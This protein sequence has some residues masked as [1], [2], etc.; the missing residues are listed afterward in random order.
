MEASVTS[1]PCGRTSTWRCWTDAAMPALGPDDL[2]ASYWTLA[3]GGYDGVPSPR[4]I[5]SRADAA[6]RAGF[7]GIGLRH[8]DFVAARDA[9][10][11][12]AE[13]R[14]AIEA[15]GVALVELE[16]VS[17]WSS[18]DPAVRERARLVEDEL[19]RAADEVGGTQMNIGCSEAY[20]AGCARDAVLERFAGLCERASAH[21]LTVA[22]EFMP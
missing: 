16:F 1:T 5:G 8:D 3:G 6:A 14:R 11:T 18:D 21:G 10:V 17:G 2:I 12:L 4:S 15:A 7:R 20:G 9:G 22:L 19:Y 13:A